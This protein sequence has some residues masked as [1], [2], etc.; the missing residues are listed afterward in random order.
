MHCSVSVFPEPDGPDERDDRLVAGPRR[1]EREISEL[2]ARGDAEHQKRS[3]AARPSASIR[4]S[5]MPM[6]TSDSALA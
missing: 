5:T 6:L 1:V 2:F 4:N 3:R